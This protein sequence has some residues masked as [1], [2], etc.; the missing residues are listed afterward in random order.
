MTVHEKINLR[1]WFQPNYTKFLT[2]KIPYNTHFKNDFWDN[3]KSKPFKL[4]N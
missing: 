3:E 4:S 1:S 2:A